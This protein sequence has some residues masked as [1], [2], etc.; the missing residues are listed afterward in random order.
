MSCP[1]IRGSRCA[2]NGML[3]S[4]FIV[5]T[6]LLALIAGFLASERWRNPLNTVSR[7]RRRLD[8]ATTWTVEIVHDGVER[9]THFF[10]SDVLLKGL[11]LVTYVALICV[12]FLERWLVRTVQLLRSFRKER[13]PRTPTHKLAQTDLHGGQGFPS[14]RGVIDNEETP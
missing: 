14:V 12:R 9:T 7:L 1:S 2:G 11:H 4:T 10:R 5:S 8:R 13:V 3:L 6:T